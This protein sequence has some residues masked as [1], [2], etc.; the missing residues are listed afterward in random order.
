MLDNRLLNAVDGLGPATLEN[1]CVFIWAHTEVAVPGLCSV[2]V[3]RR[4]SVGK[5]APRWGNPF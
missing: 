3:E 2:M 1:L 5:C 4:I